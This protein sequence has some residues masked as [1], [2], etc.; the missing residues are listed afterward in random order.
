MSYE[1]HVKQVPTQHVATNRT[2]TSLD[3]IGD[4]MTLTISKIAAGVTPAG[5]ARGAPF[6]IYWN[7]PF[8]A[9]DIDVELGIPLAPGATVADSAG[10]V[11]DIEGGPVAYTV[12]TGSYGSIG[13][14]YEALFA[15][16]K[17]HGMRP[18]GPPREIYI[19][20]PGPG[21]R[22]DEYRTEIAVPVA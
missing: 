22:P 18:I 9:D 14:A 5:A 15:W 6:A 4:A 13:A 19:V 2:H 3:T 10:A 7:E 8:K 17:Q 11:K 21:T 16:V 1:I 12:H 20:A